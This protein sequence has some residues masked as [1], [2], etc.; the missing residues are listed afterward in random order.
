MAKEDKKQAEGR[1]S[2]MGLC[3]FTEIVTGVNEI[4]REIRTLKDQKIKL[5]DPAK[6]EQENYQAF[7]KYRRRRR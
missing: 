7:D 1:A 3:K 4:K 5:V 6:F 2:S